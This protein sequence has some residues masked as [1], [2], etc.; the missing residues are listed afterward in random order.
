DI[1]GFEEYMTRV[2]IIERRRSPRSGKKTFRQSIEFV[3]ARSLPKR[4]AK[5]QESGGGAII[6]R[7]LPRSKKKRRSTPF[8]V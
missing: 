5:L 3:P 7:R 8:L 6:R 2:L 1:S 4:L